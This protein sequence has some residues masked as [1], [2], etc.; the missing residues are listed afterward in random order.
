LI[1]RRLRRLPDEQ[2]TAPASIATSTISRPSMR[3]M[4]D[5]D[6]TTPPGPAEAGH[7]E[8]RLKPDTT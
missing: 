7:Y 2:R 3:V 5:G 4:R 1:G 6:L 8:V